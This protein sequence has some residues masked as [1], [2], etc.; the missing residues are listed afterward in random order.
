MDFRSGI[1]LF[2]SDE[3]YVIYSCQELLDF[4]PELGNIV[5]NKAMRIFVMLETAIEVVYCLS[6]N[7]CDTNRQAE[8]EIFN[9]YSRK[10]QM[11]NMV[12]KHHIH[13]RLYNI[14]PV[15]EFHKTSVSTIRSA[16]LGHIIQL[17]GTVI[18]TGVVWN[19]LRMFYNGCVQIKMLEAEKEYECANSRCRYE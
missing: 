10:Q 19:Y 7:E 3:D 1:G 14:P 4:D 15:P 8:Q 9:E 12:V 5:L 2:P 17:S 16:D 11:V 18:R 6:S 13:A